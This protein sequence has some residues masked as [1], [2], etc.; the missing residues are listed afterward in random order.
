MQTKIN[1]A[2]LWHHHQPYYKNPKGYLQMPWVRFHG[3]KDS[4]E[5]KTNKESEQSL[6]CIMF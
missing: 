2:F 3:I 1:V 4:E 6:P 5:K